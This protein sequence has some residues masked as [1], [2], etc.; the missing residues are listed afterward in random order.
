[1][2]DEALQQKDAAE[3]IKQDKKLKMKE[4]LLELQ[5][6]E[7]DRVRREANAAMEEAKAVFT[8]NAVD[9]EKPKPRPSK[10]AFLTSGLKKPTNV[11]SQAKVTINLADSDDAAKTKQAE[12][13]EQTNTDFKAEN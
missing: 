6:K 12:V 3:Q 5:K 13:V 4:K 11:Q 2:S 9:T 10:A 7:Q 8:K 1:M